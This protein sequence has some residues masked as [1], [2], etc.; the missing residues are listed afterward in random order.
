M[1]NTNP[2][3][4]G[5]APHAKGLLAPLT[6]WLSDARVSEVIL[7]KP[8][9]IYVEKDGLLRRYAV[10]EFDEFTL[11]LLFQL[12][13][14][15]NNQELTPQ[16]PLLSGSLSDGARI[17]LVLPPTAGDYTFAIRRKVVRHL[18]LKDYRKTAYF[19][20]VKP[21]DVKADT[22]QSL[23]QPERELIK[24][25]KMQKWVDFIKHAITCKKNIV[26]S[27]GTSSGKTTFLNACLNEI[28][29]NE[30]IIT[31]EDTREIE[32]PHPNQVNLLAT[33][34][35][36][37]LAQV[38]MQGLVQCCLRLRPDRIIMGEIRGAEVLDFINACSTG[39]EGSLTSVHANNPRIAFMRMTQLYKLNNVP[40][41]S[42][43]DILRELKEV[44]DVIVQLHKAPKEGRMMQSI[45]YKHA[46]LVK[47]M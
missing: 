2:V 22:I 42:D 6:P 17:Q 11:N 41:M 5:Y 27:G 33:K 1:E 26:I 20:Q 32:I 4:Q 10:P 18:T 8:K 21:F 46:H 15:E 29:L 13:A 40:S 24:L 44:V 38:S 12:V 28:D 45:Y 39:H 31:L 25:Y 3:N 34:G 19:N 43:E 47:D 35:E 7:N 36:Q 23:P 30:R 9:E 16:K 14:N 37:G